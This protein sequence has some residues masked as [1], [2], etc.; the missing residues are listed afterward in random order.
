MESK[1]LKG[2]TTIALTCSDGVVLAADKRASMGHFIASSEAQKVFNINDIVGA[3]IAGGVGDAQSLMRLIKAESS[4]Y[5]MNNKEKMSAKAIAALL[6]SILHGS[7]YYPYLVQLI[8][9]GLDKG[10][11]V[12]YNLDP[13]GGASKEKMTSTGSGSPVAFGVLEQFY[14]EDKPVSENIEIAVRA[15]SS[16]MKRDSAT[17]DGISLVSISKEGFRKYSNDEIDGILEKIKK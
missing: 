14:S 8:I 2:A 13:A 1:T 3:T 10:V 11:P 15:L 17:G 12:L 6:S 5:E 16:A 9:A 7:R 4:L